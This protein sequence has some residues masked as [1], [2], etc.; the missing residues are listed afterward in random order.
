M[1]LR[2]PCGANAGLGRTKEKELLFKFPR[3]KRQFA[4]AQLCL[5][6]GRVWFIL[7]L[8]EYTGASG[9]APEGHS[10]PSAARAHA[11]GAAALLAGQWLARRRPA[12]TVSGWLQHF[13]WSSGGLLGTR[14]GA[15]ELPS[16][17]VTVPGTAASSLRRMDPA[18]PRPRHCSSQR[19]EHTAARGPGRPLSVVAVTTDRPL[20][21]TPTL[22]WAAVTKRNRLVPTE[23]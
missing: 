15:G 17:P 2:A 5:S 14:R 19:P 1:T 21:V 7:L 23:K 6:T 11:D 16:Q 3:R 18:L 4:F 20:T 13:T 9:S 22:T 12:A 8:A 10:S